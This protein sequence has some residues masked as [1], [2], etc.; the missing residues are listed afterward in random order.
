MGRR[1]R[2]A[3]NSGKPWFYN[4]IKKDRDSFLTDEVDQAITRTVLK[5]EKG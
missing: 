1:G 3:A 5:I 4:E 2:W